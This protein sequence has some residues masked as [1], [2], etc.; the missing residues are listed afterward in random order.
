MKSTRALNSNQFS[1]TIPASLGNL[2]NV[3]WLDL[4]YNQLSG[5]LPISSGTSP[6]LDLLVH[7]QHLWVFS[8]TL[9]ATLVNSQ[10]CLYP[11][12]S[13]LQSFQPKQSIRNHSRKTF[14]FSDAT[15]THVSCYLLIV[16]FFMVN[17]GL[18]LST[19]CEQTFR[20]E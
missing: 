7:T 20:W 16:T 8:F 10:T 4:S 2:S 11:N 19:H 6:G 3:Y 18:N 13:S 12:I 1:G 17:F 9:K 15:D 5:Q 14:Q